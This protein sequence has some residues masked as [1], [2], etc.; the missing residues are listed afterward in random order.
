MYPMDD[1]Q[2]DTHRERAKGGWI[3]SSFD[4]TS[5]VTV[6]HSALTFLFGPFCCHRQT[7][8]FFRC[9]FQCD[10]NLFSLSMST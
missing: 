1:A 2:L 7:Q 5:G 9:Q 10:F 8:H 6:T 4:D 3:E